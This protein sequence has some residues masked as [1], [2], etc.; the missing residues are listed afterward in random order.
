MRM[1]PLEIFPDKHALAESAAAHAVTTLQNAVAQHGTATWVLTGGTTPELAY[2]L[3]ADHYLGQLDWSKV[4]FIM[5]DERIAPL[6]SP[7]SNWHMAEQLL[8]KHIPQATFLRPVSNQTAE[9]GAGE[10]RGQLSHLPQ[11]N[12]LPRFDLVWLGMG[13]DGHT[14]SLFPNHPDFTPTEQLVIPVHHS[15]KPPADR[16]TLTLAALSGAQTTVILASGNGKANAVALAMQPSSS[17]PIA[18]AA[19]LTHALWFLDQAA[20]R[21]IP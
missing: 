10:Y 13:E 17:L 16:I 5:G 18:Q 2:R 7:D 15:P 6:N 3:L 19:R 21:L 8:L 20:A 11:R 9:V 1:R 12:G 14:L 4:T